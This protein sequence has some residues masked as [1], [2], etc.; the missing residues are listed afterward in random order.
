MYGRFV[1]THNDITVCISHVNILK[2]VQIVLVCMGVL[3]F[4]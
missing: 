3:T 1:D 2:D 4:L